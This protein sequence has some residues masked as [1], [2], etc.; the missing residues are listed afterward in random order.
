[1]TPTIN[2]NDKLILCVFYRPPTSNLIY[3]ENLCPFFSGLVKQNFNIP[4]WISGDLNLPNINWETIRLQLSNYFML[5]FV[6]NYR[7]L[8]TVSLPTRCDHILDIFLTNLP[9]FIQS[10]EVLPGISDHEVVYVVS[11]VLV[12][13]YRPNQE[14]FYYGTKLTLR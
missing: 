12:S 14:E 5:D 1:M 9:T 3:L 11:S 6:K 7:F 4:I 10:C 2:D 8:Q 13:Y